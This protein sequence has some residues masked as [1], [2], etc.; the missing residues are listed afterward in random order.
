MG[1]LA[2]DSGLC[3]THLDFELDILVLVNKEV[4]AIAVAMITSHETHRHSPPI[5]LV[6]I[7]LGLDV[8]NDS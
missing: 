6:M 4:T 1:L 3:S 2:D 5:S 8:L 7:L